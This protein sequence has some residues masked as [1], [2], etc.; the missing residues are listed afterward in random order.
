M[1]QKQ[2]HYFGNRVM[3]PRD[4]RWKQVWTDESAMWWA[5]LIEI[6]NKPAWELMRSNI[7]GVH[8]QFDETLCQAC[9]TSISNQ[10]DCRICNST[11]F[12]SASILVRMLLCHLISLVLPPPPLPIPLPPPPPYHRSFFIYFKL[13]QINDLVELHFYCLS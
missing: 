2:W 5:E 8:L 1:W 6:G 11:L 7:C 9:L 3:P 12:A 13:W 4:G 10:W